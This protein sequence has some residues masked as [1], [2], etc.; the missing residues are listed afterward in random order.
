MK[1]YFPELEL[2]TTL[3]DIF[4]AI[5]PYETFEEF[6]NET[7]ENSYDDD[8]FSIDYLEGGFEASVKTTFFEVINYI[9]NLDVLLKHFPDY[10]Q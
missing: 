6:K 7:L 4:Q 10:D 3:E 5:K 9:N 1:V 2:E 8:H